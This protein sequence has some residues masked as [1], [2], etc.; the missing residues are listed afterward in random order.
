MIVFNPMIDL[1]KETFEK[2]SVSFNEHNNP[3]LVLGGLRIEMTEEQEEKLRFY[4][5]NT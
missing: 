2:V 1:T 4:Y 3:I 5:E